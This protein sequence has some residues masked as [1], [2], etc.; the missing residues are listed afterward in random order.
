MFGNAEVFQTWTRRLQDLESA[1]DV[2]EARDALSRARS[3]ARDLRR[4]VKR[5]SQLPSQ[6]IVQ[7]KILP[8]LMEAEKQIDRA[9]SEIDRKNPLA[10]VEHDPVPD[11][12]SEIVRRYYESLGQ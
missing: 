8:S 10:P 11:S 9:L 3:A 4:D 6:A 1:V 12:Y 2:P 7:E 5:N